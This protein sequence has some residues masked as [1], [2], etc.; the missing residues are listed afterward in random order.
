[1]AEAK[2]DD[3]G[4]TT[5]AVAYLL[6]YSTK[7][8][9]KSFLVLQVAEDYTT[10]VGAVVLRAR[11]QRLPFALARV[12]VILLCM[13]SEMAMLASMARRWSAVRPK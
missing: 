2:L 10:A 9:L 8:F 11:N 12:V 4:V 7:E 1:M 13:I 5:G 3:T 6:S